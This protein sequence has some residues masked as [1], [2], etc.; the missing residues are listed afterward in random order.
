MGASRD[1]REWAPRGRSSVAW[2]HRTPRAPFDLRRD[3]RMQTAARRPF[4]PRRFGLQRVMSARC[5]SRAS[6]H[7]VCSVAS[8]HG[9]CSFASSVGNPEKGLQK[10]A[11]SPQPSTAPPNALGRSARG[12]SRTDQRARSLRKHQQ[13]PHLLHRH[14]YNLK[15]RRCSG[16]AVRALWAHVRCALDYRVRDLATRSPGA[17]RV[18][19]L[20]AA[21]QGQALSAAAAAPQTGSRTRVCGW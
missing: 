12:L 4:S 10:E 1:G 3:E 21:P 6:C 8:C 15:P 17:R 13:R 16:G 7:V 18:A 9:V 20:G 11:P 19:R 5:L 14:L 2:A